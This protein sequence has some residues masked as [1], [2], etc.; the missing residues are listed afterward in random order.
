VRDWADPGSPFHDKIANMWVEFDLAVPP[1]GL[2]HPVAVPSVFLGGGDHLKAEHADPAAHSWLVDAVARLSGAPVSAERRDVIARCLAALPPDGRLFQTGV[3]LARTDPV[4]RLCLRGPKPADLPAYLAAVGWPGP[5]AE[6][7][8]LLDRLAGFAKEILIHLDVGASVRQRL[9]LECY[10]EEGEALAARLSAFLDFLR[11]TALCTPEKAGAL[12]AWYGLTH[13]KWCRE[14]WPRD[15]REHAERPGPGHS[16]AFLR[17]LHHVKLTFDP[18][19]PLSAKAYLA[20]RFAWV[21]DAALKRA[22]AEQ[23]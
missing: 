1:A 21:D 4:L 19:E 18:P 9:G 10:L 12:A 16:G 8:A 7:A 3:M 20:A 2:D 11:E 6:V 13:E 22:L 23:K 14:H 15:L 5:L 17:S